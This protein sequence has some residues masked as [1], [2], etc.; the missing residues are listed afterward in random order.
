MKQE[1][2][3]MI[4][5]V[6]TAIYL[7]GLIAVVVSSCVAFHNNCPPAAEDTQKTNKALN[8]P[9]LAFWPPDMVPHPMPP[10]VPSNDEDNWA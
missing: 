2:F 8:N 6:R 4:L 9:K 5:K 7:S 3:K 10:E 1:W